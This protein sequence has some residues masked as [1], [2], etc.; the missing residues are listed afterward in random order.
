MRTIYRTLAALGSALLLA[1]CGGDTDVSELE[2]IDNSDEVAAYYTAK[3]EFFAFKTLA[4]IPTDLTWEDGSHLP[5]IGSDKAVKGGTLYNTIQDFPRTLRRVGPDSNGSFRPFILDYTTLGIAHRHPNEFDFYPGLA[6]QWAVDKPNKTVY[7]KL[8]PGA[9]WSDGEAITSDDFMF[10]FFMYQS[11]YIVAPWYNNWYATQYTNITK[12]DD[13]NFSIT[14][15]DAK[16]DMD[17]RVLELRP[18]P[19]HFYKELG[20]DYVERYQWKF[21]PTTGPYVIEDKDI[22]KGVSIALTRQKDWW[23]KDNKFWRN[24]YNPDRIHISVIRDTSKVFEAFKRGDLDQFGLNLAEYWYD[25][26]PNSDKDVQSGFIQKSV[27]YNQHPRPTYGLWMN[28][29]KPLLNNIDIRS[30]IQHATN[31]QLVIDKFFRGD[32]VRM[33]TSS[34]GYGEFTHPTL[35]SRGYDIEKAQDYFAKAGFVNRGPDGILVNE[36]GERLSLTLTTGYERFKDILTI[37]KEEASKTGLEFRIEVLDGTAGWKK[38]QEKKHDISFSALSASLEMY[39]RFWETY[40]SDNAY[41]QAFLADGSVNAERSVKTQTNNMEMMAVL[42]MDQMIEAYRESDDKQQ[43]VELAHKMTQLHHDAASFSPGFYQPFYRVG[44][45]RWIRYPDDFNVK[46]SR[47]PG[48]YYVQWI[49]TKLKEETLAARK[50]DD[51]F[52]PE[53]NVFDQY[54]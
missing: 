27:F 26:L 28:S 35:K 45:W 29:H 39:P 40:H 4:D 30:G 8:N 11:S 18:A 41:D 49:D 42:E 5:D 32:Y 15:P 44:H 34:D 13:Q 23:G 22:K 10:M 38:I 12:Y 47:S 51:T 48:E 53:V 9:R 16:P 43:M 52:E 2:V 50:S 36:N 1:S 20:E 19:Q 37:L 7:V 17:S 25:K 31:W 24:R 54:K 3:P 6:E 14:I 21:Q 46:H 33:Q